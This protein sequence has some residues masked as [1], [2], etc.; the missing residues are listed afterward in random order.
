MELEKIPL[1]EWL[2]NPNTQPSGYADKEYQDRFAK[3]C[4]KNGLGDKPM[5]IDEYGELVDKFENDWNDEEE[6]KIAEQDYKQIAED[7]K[8]DH[9]SVGQMI[10]DDAELKK[11]E[12]AFNDDDEMTDFQKSLDDYAKKNPKGR[13]DIPVGYRR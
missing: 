1:S 4:E 2:N 9:R 5:N 7:M 10:E 6:E 8:T 12:N 3:Y 11:I 13:E